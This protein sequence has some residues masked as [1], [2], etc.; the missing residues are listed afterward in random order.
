MRLPRSSLCILVMS[1]D[2]SAPA[3]T[4]TALQGAV[5]GTRPERAAVSVS[6]AQQLY[7]PHLIRVDVCGK[8]IR[9]CCACVGVLCSR[10]AALPFF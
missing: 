6:I 10:A 2:D 3:K 7:I 4:S 8:S 5:A 9:G 1:Q